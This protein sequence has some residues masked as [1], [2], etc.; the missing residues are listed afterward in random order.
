MAKY[1]KLSHTIWYCQYHVVWTPKYR[2]RV[3]SGRVALDVESS[4]RMFSAMQ[5]IEIVEMSIQIDH[6]HLILNVPPKHSIS[7]VIGVLKGRSAIRVFQKFK[8]LKR[9]PYWGNHFW[10]RGYCVSTIGLDADKVRRYVRYQENIE[11]KTE[12]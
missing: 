2:F 7:H 9:K 4:L 10:A 3:L 8:E 12:K 6:V 1:Q 5:G 11:R